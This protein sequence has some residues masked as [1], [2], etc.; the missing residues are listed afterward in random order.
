[1][2]Q[3]KNIL[4]MSLVVFIPCSLLTSQPVQQSW[5]EWVKSFFMTTNK[6]ITQFQKAVAASTGTGKSLNLFPFYKEKEDKAEQNSLINPTIG[7]DKFKEAV[8]KN[9]IIM[10]WLN[11]TP[12]KFLFGVSSSSYQYEGGL[13]DNN[14]SALFYRTKKWKDAQKVEK[15]GWETAGI[16][17]DFWHRYEEDIRRMKYELGINCFRLSIAWDRVQP[18]A[19]TW[20]DTALAEYKKI[21]LLL[22]QYAIEPIIVLHHYTIPQ[23]FAELDGFEKKENIPYFVNFAKKMYETLH[24]D[25]IYWS[26]FN[27]IEGYAFKGYFTEDGPPGK[28]DLLTTEKVINNMLDAH[29]QTYKAIK[30][31]SGIFF[32]QKGLYQEYKRKKANIPN[33]Q[34]GIQKNIVLFDPFEKTNQGFCEKKGSQAICSFSSLLNDT[35]FFKLLRYKYK[36]S[37]DWIGVNIYSN[38]FML[39]S[40]KQQEKDIDRKTENLNYRD[41][42]EGI[43]RAVKIVYDNIAKPF[44]IPI[45]ITENGIATKNDVAGDAKRTRFF[46]RALYTIR[47]LIQEGYPIIGYTPWASHD[48]YE[49][50]SADQPNPY[51]RPYGLFKVDTNTKSPTYLQRTLKKGAQYYRDFIRH[52]LTGEKS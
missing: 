48:N 10:K 13:D 8:Q 39:Y 23:W 42:P 52:Y 37:L 15:I 5:S 29:A 24:E 27:A 40:Q 2:K 3:I 9:H 26:T 30:G 38:M 25:V 44:N 32:G 16:A 28:K 4:L 47:K 20:N 22:K 12:E 31:S 35:V 19:D 18:T 34:I 36:S 1:M 7:A 6:K 21:I 33:P 51:D 50:P 49:W 43:Y 17:I 46:R 45:I 41:Y 14:A 11:N